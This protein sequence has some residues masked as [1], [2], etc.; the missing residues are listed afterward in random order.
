MAIDPVSPVSAPLAPVNV[1][2]SRDAGARADAYVASPADRRA[3]LFKG[4]KL[5]R[6]YAKGAKKRYV[7]PQRKKTAR[8]EVDALLHNAN[9]V[10]LIADSKINDARSR[11]RKERRERVEAAAGAP[12]APRLVDIR[13]NPARKADEHRLRLERKG[14]VA[15]RH[16]NRRSAALRAAG[17]RDVADHRAK[18][19]EARVSIEDAS[20]AVLKQAANSPLGRMSEIT[21]IHGL[22][23][24]DIYLLCASV[25]EAQ[26]GAPLG[27]AYAIA[28][29]HPDQRDVHGAFENL[30]GYAVRQ[31]DRGVQPREAIAIGM[32]RADTRTV[33]ATAIG[34]V[35]PWSGQ[36]RGGASPAALLPAF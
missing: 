36:G 28:R 5:W 4:T 16:E 2:R 10:Q 14:D 8:E 32:E 33:I 35:T 1:D 19:A 30:V 27:M 17:A 13:E 11:E 18:L 12:G 26:R 31:N 23:A 9:G 6:S 20:I 22:P 34:L 21:G 29:P 15:T 25:L 3:T 7:Q 24:E